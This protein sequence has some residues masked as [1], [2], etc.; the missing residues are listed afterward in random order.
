MVLLGFR[1]LSRYKG[2]YQKATYDKS[3]IMTEFPSPLEV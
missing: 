1:P 2:S 3:G